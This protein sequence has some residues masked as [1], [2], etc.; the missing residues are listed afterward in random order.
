MIHLIFC[1]CFWLLIIAIS[2]LRIWQSSKKAFNYLS[3]LHKIPCSRC[4]FFTGDYRLKCTVA[5]LKAMS[6]EAIDCRDFEQKCPS[7]TNGLINRSSFRWA[8]RKYQ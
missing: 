3:Q 8:K 7:Q 4:A 2:I 1:Y 5:P 6:E